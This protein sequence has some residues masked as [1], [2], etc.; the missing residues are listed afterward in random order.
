VDDVKYL[1]APSTLPTRFGDRIL[2]Q[3]REV[4]ERGRGRCR[5]DSYLTS[6]AKGGHGF[7]FSYYYLNFGKDVF[8]GDGFPYLVF[9]TYGR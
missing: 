5:E 2:Q 1:S 4:N 3:Q 9:C 8:V 7:V 6:G